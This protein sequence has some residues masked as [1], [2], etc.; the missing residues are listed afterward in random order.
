VESKG[1]LYFELQSRLLEQLRDMVRN[2]QYSERSLA[3]A[4]G[5]SQPHVHNVLKGARPL[6]LEVSDQILMRLRLSVLDL[7]APE[8]LLEAERRRR[9]AARRWVTVTLLARPLG[10]SSRRRD[11]LRPGTEQM[12]IPRSWLQGLASPFAVRANADPDMDPVIREGDLLLADIGAPSALDPNALYAVD[13]P[14][15]I[16]ARWLRLGANCIYLIDQRTRNLPSQW[17]R[18]QFPSG[19]L[20]D[21]VLARLIPLPAPLAAL[22]E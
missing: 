20:G 12:R 8:E 9:A 15:G 22:P 17:I 6:T 2:G 5:L 1:V 11:L 14:Q 7:C 13:L 19:R 10:G 21:L 18:I 16:R 3:Q 4:T